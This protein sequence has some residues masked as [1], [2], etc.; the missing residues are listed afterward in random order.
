MKQL[1]S[2]GAILIVAGLASSC[3]SSNPA[4]PTAP[5]A[6]V[7]LRDGT[8][9]AGAVKSSSAKEITV[10]G[11]DNNSRTFDMK[12]VRSIEY[13]DTAAAP[14]AATAPASAPAASRAAIERPRPPRDP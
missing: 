12:N 7:Y 13:G 4:D 11:D 5:R 10:A 1:I 8:S 2:I 3:S 9:Y 14:A 6:T